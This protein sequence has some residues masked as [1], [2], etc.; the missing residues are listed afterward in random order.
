[1]KKFKLLL[2]LSI[3]FFALYSCEKQTEITS[4]ESS[5]SKKPITKPFKSISNGTD[6]DYC[7]EPVECTLIAGQSIDAGTVSV[8]NDGVN[9]YVTVYSISGFQDVD[10]N[11]KMWI[12]TNLPSGRPAAGKFPYKVTESGNTHIF[13]IPLSSFDGWTEDECEQHYYI[14]VHADVKVVNG[15]G[16]DEE[17]AFGGCEEGGGKAWWYYMEYATSCCEEDMECMDAF[18]RK[19]NDRY[20]FCINYND[21]ERNSKITWSSQLDFNLFEGVGG[22]S[23]KI[24]LW[25]NVDQCNPWTDAER[26][27]I[28]YV[29]VSTF[30]EGVGDGMKL[31]ADMKYWIK[32]EFK[33]EYQFSVVNVYFGLYADS[34]DDNGNA[35][36]PSGDKFYQE[37]LNGGSEFTLKRLDWPGTNGNLAWDTY[38]ISHVKIC[39]IK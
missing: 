38:F 39:E 2:S 33:D 22:A 21:D 18:A 27:N 19:D 7:G 12:G 36:M 28:G 34:F 23:H 4:L 1:M 8:M 15:D 32:D 11:I 9:L 25:V 31:Y 3:L 16:F 17:T 37:E 26:V 20:S 35:I 6:I 10:E 5:E 30:S 24:R 29:T 13:Q 14:I